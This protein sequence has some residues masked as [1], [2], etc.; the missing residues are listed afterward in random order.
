[1]RSTAIVNNQPYFINNY[2]IQKDQNGNILSEKD[3]IYM[4][5]AGSGF[6]FWRYHTYTKTFDNHP[7][8]LYKIYP[9]RPFSYEA[10]KVY[11]DF[12]YDGA[13]QKNNILSEVSNLSSPTSPTIINSHSYTYTYLSN[14]YPATMIVTNDITGQVSKGIFVY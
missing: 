3:S 11:H 12:F 1:M 2:Q 10:P 13:L 5:T 6:D 4:Y 9:K 8:P 14:G 7:C